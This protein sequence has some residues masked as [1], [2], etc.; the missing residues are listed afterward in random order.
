MNVAVLQSYPTQQ[1]PVWIRQT[2]ASVRDWAGLHGYHYVFTDDAFFDYAPAWV[3]QRCKTQFFPITDIAR[4]HYIQAYLDKGYQRVVWVDADVLV[5]DPKKLD[6]RQPGCHAFSREVMLHCLSDGSIRIG[7][8]G[9]N[10]AVM[11]FDQGSPVLPL[12][13]DAAENCLRQTPAEA[14]TRTII[15]PQLLQ[16]LDATHPLTRMNNIGLFTPAL[17]QDLARGSTRWWHAWQ[18]AHGY[19]LAAA[20]LC[21]FVRHQADA[22]QQQQLDRIYQ[23]A[24]EVIY[25]KQ[26]ESV[27]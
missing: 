10:N 11:Y 18:Q 1:V 5:F 4:L 12:Y 15:G 6:I 24:I 23:Q 16:R 27:L 25:A 3:R 17:L 22:R 7:A 26:A 14:I 9:L 20:N 2:L 13:L 21:H 8:L 19:P